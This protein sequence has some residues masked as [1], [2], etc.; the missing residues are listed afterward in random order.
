MKTKTDKNK[1]G[2]NETENRTEKQSLANRPPPPATI[3]PRAADGP[4]PV[5]WNG[6]PK[7]H[8][9]SRFNVQNHNQELV[10]LPSIKE[11]RAYRLRGGSARVVRRGRCARI[12]AAAGAVACRSGSPAAPAASTAR[13]RA[14]SRSDAAAGRRLRWST[15]GR[16]SARP[17]ALC[18]PPLMR[19]RA[20]PSRHSVYPSPPLSTPAWTWSRARPSAPRACPT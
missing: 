5:G 16:L 9:S 18:S 15:P 8:G 2:E 7:R 17:P 19:N 6:Q 11:D 4:R 14:G 12:G 3:V 1:N 10:K 13:R 20:A